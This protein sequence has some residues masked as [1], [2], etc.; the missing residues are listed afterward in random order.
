[1]RLKDGCDT[2]VHTIDVFGGYVPMTAD[3]VPFVTEFDVDF[4]TDGAPLVEIYHRMKQ[5]K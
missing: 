2:I 4:L 1:M 3:K 5:L